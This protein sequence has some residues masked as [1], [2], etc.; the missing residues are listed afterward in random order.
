LNG[1]GQHDVGPGTPSTVISGDLAKMAANHATQKAIFFQRDNQRA[2][3][4]KKISA[5]TR[6]RR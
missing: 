3:P 5:R 2:N 6:S 4:L 1:A